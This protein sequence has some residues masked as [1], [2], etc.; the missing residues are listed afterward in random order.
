MNLIIHLWIK[1]LFLTFLIL[2]AF[3]SIAHSKFNN[4]NK[5]INISF[6]NINY[7]LLLTD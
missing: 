7:K 3:N 5:N 2:M 6:L 1:F 4:N